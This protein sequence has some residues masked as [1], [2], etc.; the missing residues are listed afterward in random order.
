M[1]TVLDQSYLSP[2]PVTIR[3]VLW[4][5]TH[6][7]SLFPLPNYLILADSTTPSFTVTYEG[8][9]VINPGVFLVPDGRRKAKY[10]EFMVG[11]QAGAG[12]KIEEFYY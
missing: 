1:K 3:P 10:A 12:G 6:T 2:Y 4:D 8:S 11:A 5:Y 7:L 9:H